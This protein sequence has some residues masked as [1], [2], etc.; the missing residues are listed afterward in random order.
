MLASPCLLWLL[1]MTFSLVPRAQPLA[2][3][4]FEEEEEDGTAL[5]PA[6]PCDYDRCRHLQVPCKELQRAGPTACLCPGLSSPGQPPEPP[7]LGEVHVVAQEGLA[8]VHWCAPSSPVH[9]YWLLLRE[10]NRA[11]Q[12]GPLLNATFRRTELKGLKPGGS[13]IVCVVAANEAGESQ[14]PGWEGPEGADVSAFGPCRRLSVPPTPLTLVHTAVGV[15]TALALLS[16][17]ALVWHFCLRER[18]GCPRSAPSRAAG[19]L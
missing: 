3:Q 13:Y 14:V 16:C 1:A 8:I 12:K 17:S 18:W 2:P 19:A 11:P 15:G 4:D 10:G 9:H 7:R 6:V 5:P